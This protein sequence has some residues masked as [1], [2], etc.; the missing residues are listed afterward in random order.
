MADAT[1]AILQDPINLVPGINAYAKA[2]TAARAAAMAGRSALGAG[3]RSGARAGAV[4]EALIS[5]AQEG[6]VNTAN[7]IRD[8]QI[9]ARDDFSA[10]E[11]AGSMATGTVI[12]GGVGGLI[13]AGTGAVASRT[14]PKQAQASQFL[15]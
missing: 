13:G 11:L 3:V 15:G 1:G 5:G 7:Q 12:G 10:G 9:G 6:I 2:T 14:G 4:S 8:I